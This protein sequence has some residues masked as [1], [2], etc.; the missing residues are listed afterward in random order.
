MVPHLADYMRPNAGLLQRYLAD[1]NKFTMKSI[2]REFCEETGMDECQAVEYLCK[3][4][5]PAYDLVLDFCIS[6]QPAYITDQTLAHFYMG[7][8]LRH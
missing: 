3:L 4:T 7:W 8:Y 6:N 5:Q 1:Y 2:M